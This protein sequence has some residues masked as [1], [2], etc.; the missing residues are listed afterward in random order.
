[1]ITRRHCLLGAPAL[2]SGCVTIH[3]EDSVVR[4][5]QDITRQ[6]FKG[7]KQVLRSDGTW[8]SAALPEA[9][10]NRPTVWYLTAQ[11]SEGRQGFM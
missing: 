3:G 7:D 1:M 9:N 6:D 4:V 8:A 10:I 2:L 11:E 5:G